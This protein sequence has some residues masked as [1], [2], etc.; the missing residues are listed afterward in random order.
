MSAVGML[1]VGIVLVGIVLVGI[2]LVGCSGS[3]TIIGST[4]PQLQ[5]TSAP[6]ATTA[7][8]PMPTPGP[9]IQRFA[10]IPLEPPAVASAPWYP[11]ELVAEPYGQA[12]RG[13]LTFRGSPN[14]SYYGQGPVP[15]N[16]RVQWSYPGTKMCSLST[17]PD[18]EREWCGTGWTGQ[19]AVWERGGE[20]WVAFGAYDRNVHVLDALTGRPR[21]DPFPTGD[22]IKG[23]LTVDPD[24]H[25]LIYVG[26]RDNF[27]RVLSFDSGELVERWR[28]SAYAVEDRLWNDDWDGAPAII[29][30]YMFV[31]GENANLHVVKLNRGYDRDGRVTVDPSLIFAVPG[32]DDE[33]LQSIGD[34]NVSIENSVTIVD[35]VVY[36]ANSGG[37]V[38]GWD[39]SG[40]ADGVEPTRVF[41]FWLGDDI[42][43]SVVVDDEGFLYAAAE[44]ERG[45]ERSRTLGQVVKLDPR[46]PDDPVVWSADARTG[47]DTGVWA[48]PAVYRDIVIVPTADGRVLGLDR[49]TGETRWSL[50]LPGPVWSSPVVI[51]DTLVQADCRGLIHGYDLRD[52]TIEPPRLWSVTVGACIESTP[53]V[54]K[55]RIWV[56]TRGGFFHMIGDPE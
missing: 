48:T 38:Q 33:L 50:R 1:P 39:I 17:D 16:P 41:R 31:G 45:T 27:L 44:Y 5:P 47:I 28:L 6:I 2:L 40:V 24:G 8:A 37:L 26:S 4:D 30:D 22:L 52:L 20:L 49:A 35:D 54:W 46:R 53:V 55:N 34:T 23:S 15:Q 18:G 19:P 9:A 21:M 13:V 29:D 10:P 43:A 12:V 14:R 42:D 11:R 36:F 56:G 3:Q 7:P 51:D 32:W 25:P